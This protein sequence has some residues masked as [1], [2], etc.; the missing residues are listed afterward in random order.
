MAL[1]D[2]AGLLL[3]LATAIVAVLVYRAWTA[4]TSP[5]FHIPAPWYANFTGNVLKYHTVAGRR[6]FYIH[7]LH[8]KYGPVV[9][10]SPYEVSVADPDSFIAIHRMGSGFNKARFYKDFIG[11]SKPGIF[12]MTDTRDHAARRKLFA[13]AFSTSS[14]RENCEVTVREKVEKAVERISTEAKEG[15]ADIHKWWMLMATDIVGQ[16]CFG[17]SFGMLELGE[18]NHYV[19]VLD[20][21]ASASTIRYELPWLHS[22]LC[23][24]PL[25]SMQLITNTRGE[26]FAYSKRA[27]ENLRR[28]RDNKSNLFATILAECGTGIDGNER[29]VEDIV[30]GEAA[31]M[32][33]AGSDTVSSSL[34]YLIWSILKRP[35]LLERLTQE[36][37]GLDNN[38]DDAELERLPLLNAVINESL[39]L[40]GSVQGSMPRTTPA[41]G[42]TFCGIFIPGGTVVTTQTYTMHRLSEVFPDPFRWVSL[43]AGTL[44]EAAY[45]FDHRFD[46]K[47]FLPGNPT[48]RQKQVF[49]PFGSGSRSCLGVSL[50]KMEMRL[51][52]VLLL[53]RFPG[54]KLS[55]KM[56]DEMMEMASFMIVKPVA[57]KCDVTSS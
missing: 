47:R 2:Q 13:R 48:E 5:L 54:L 33:I 57:N 9:R 11:K 34:T 27:V 3:F 43:N 37:S 18:K 38:F 23:R 51:A 8:Q 55:D 52:T 44:T 45:Q 12:S 10:I 30:R 41:S 19:Q 42:V 53:R 31:N 56:T 28:N 36:L 1:F 24:L 20:A 25:K 4:S 49:S 17:E 14:L 39:R 7:A 40:Y 6:M 29:L 35:G 21:V 15:C 50:A 26:M 32:M 22:V 16:L 46:E